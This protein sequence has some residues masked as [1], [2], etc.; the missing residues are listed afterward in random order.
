MIRYYRPQHFE[1]EELIPPETLQAL[2]RKAWLVLDPRA[3]FTL[4]QLR[5]AFGICT[6]NDWHE[7]V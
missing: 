6:V 1:L 5:D 3:L 2:G 4:D 7:F